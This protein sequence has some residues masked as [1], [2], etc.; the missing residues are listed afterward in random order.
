M[1][2]KFHS[3]GNVFHFGTKFSWNDEIDT[4][5]NVEFLLLSH[6]FDFLDGYLV[7]TARYWWL[8]LVTARYC[9]FPLLV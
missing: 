8:L 5:F 3:I 7:V 1:S 9:S 2:A 6:N 4:C